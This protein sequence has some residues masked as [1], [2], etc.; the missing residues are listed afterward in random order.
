M[1][2]MYITHEKNL[3]GATKALIELVEKVKVDN[4]VYVV[5]PFNKGNAY[6]E[7]KKLGVNIIYIKH[8]DNIT[9]KINFKNLIKGY[10][11]ILI[12][13]IQSI[14][15]SVIAKKNKID[16]IHTNCSIINLGCMVSYLTGIP[17]IFHIREISEKFGFKY[18]RGIEKEMKFVKKNSAQ[19]IV[20]SKYLYSIYE[21]YFNGKIQLIYDGIDIDKVKT[22]KRRNNKN[23]INILNCGVLSIT[24]G[25]EDIIRALNELYKKGYS[26]IKLYFAGNSDAEYE[27]KIKDEVKKYNLSDKVKFLGFVDDMKSLRENMDIEVN[28]SRSEGFGR[29]TVEAMIS[30]NPIIAAK[31][32]ATKEIVQDKVNGFLYET[33]NYK[34]LSDNIEFI[35]K[36]KEKVNYMVNVAYNKAIKL[37]SNKENKK[38]IVQL[39][40]KITYND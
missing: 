31:N 30:K 7:F 9:E 8:F 24:K 1:N 38:K 12:N 2:I 19:I 32:T 26:N 34:Q 15:L 10:V 40:K 17:N 33:G 16:I 5:I 35:I 25:Q 11:K 23:E 29:T 4:N 27:K 20:I 36:N 21:K 13:C 3:G 39:Y 28:C 18:V 14:R 37:Y 6:K 22:S